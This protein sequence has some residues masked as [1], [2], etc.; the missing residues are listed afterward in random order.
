VSQTVGT[1]NKVY[2]KHSI[3]GSCTAVDS[4]GARTVAVGQHVIVLADTNTK[5]WTAAN[6]PDSAFYAS[7]A[8][9]YDQVTWPHILNNI[10]NPLAYDASLSSTGKI[11]VTITPVLNNFASA[12]GGGSIVAF[13][14][15]CDFFPA[16]SSGPNA[17][18][19][20]QTEMFYSWTPDASTGWDP[21]SWGQLLRAT[22]AHETKHIV[23]YTDR[24]MNN[25]ANFEEIWLEEGLAQA[26]S[27]I[28]ER[29]FNQA[30]WLGNAN[31]LQ[32]VACELDLG[33]NAPCDISGTKPIALTGSHLP[34]LFE[35]LQTESASGS[36]GLGL[37]TPANY[38]A[39]WTISRWAIDQY[40]NGNEGTF[41]KTLINE[42]QLTGVA[43][44]VQHT[45]QSAATLLVYWN[46]AMATFQDRAYTAADTRVNFPS[47]DLIN[48]FEIGQTGLTCG[49]VRCGLFTDSGS[50]EFPIAPLPVSTATAFTKNF[51]SVPGTSAQYF[52][53]TATA[54]GVEH[55]QLLSTSGQPLSASSGFRVA[56]LRVQ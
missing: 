15:G 20:N 52:V 53:L 56:I 54:A 22:A 17:D 23:S 49:G 24:I 4:I 6:R 18:L 2:V 31:F 30:T 14:N 3:S 44:L 8:S 48:I 32:T 50:P 9:E 29:N 13:V 21:V 19:S 27:E 34:F 41:I 28:W 10:G 33:S 25:S 45:G 51:L 5:T 35:Y 55:L 39:G 42:P 43:N 36:E 46:L 1:I 37:D 11:T 38:G 7:F 12:A 26:S 47:F 16:A 40:A